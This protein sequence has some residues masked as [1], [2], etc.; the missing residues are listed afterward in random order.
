MNQNLSC[1]C[2]QNFFG[3]SPTYRADF[4]SQILDI[5]YNSNGGISHDEAYNMP[6]WLR[7]FNYYGLA[8]KRKKENE[9]YEKIK[10]Q[11]KGKA[12]RK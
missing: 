1:Q 7:K 12:P 10:N 11:S 3:L 4:H 2:F 9:E 6:I 5:I 8:E